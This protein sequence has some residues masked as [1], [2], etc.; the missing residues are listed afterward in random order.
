MDLSCGLRIQGE[1]V[2]SIADE[3]ARERY[4][5]RDGESERERTL[6]NLGGNIETP[7]SEP[8]CLEAA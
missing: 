5:E 6:M 7:H 1:V 3:N 2:S 8:D 4:R